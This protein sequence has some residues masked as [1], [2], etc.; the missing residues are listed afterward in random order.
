MRASISAGPG[1]GGG[2]GSGVLVGELFLDGSAFLQIA[3]FGEGAAEDEVAPM[4]SEAK[5]SSTL[6]SGVNSSISLMRVWAYSSSF[7]GRTKSRAACRICAHPAVRLSG[8]P[9]AKDETGVVPRITWRAVRVRGCRR[10]GESG[11]LRLRT[12]S[13][14]L[15]RLRDW[16]H[17]SHYD[18]AVVPLCDAFAT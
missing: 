1:S 15:P 5:V 8:E 4:I 18:C 3:E 13:Q 12:G 7:S 16:P 17:D 11:G 9:G 6:F 14:A 10:L 2:L